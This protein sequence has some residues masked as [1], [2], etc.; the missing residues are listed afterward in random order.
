MNPKKILIVDKLNSSKLVIKELY[1]LG[2]EPIDFF[3]QKFVPKKNNFFDKLCNL[4]YRNI[5]NNTKYY[6]EKFHKELN[7]FCKINLLEIKKSYPEISY[8]L[9]FS[10]EWLS[11]EVLSISRGICKKMISYHYDGLFSRNE[12]MRIY[13]NYFDDI[14]SF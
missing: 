13:K 10:P 9:F 11:E 14:Y 2:Y 5:L 3:A 6:E 8:G 12:K 1:R 7:I 4:Y